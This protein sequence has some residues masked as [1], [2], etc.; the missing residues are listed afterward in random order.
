MGR[1]IRA[2]V[3]P[4]AWM[5]RLLAKVQLADEVKRV[6]REREKVERKLRKLGQVYLND[7]LMDYEEYRRQKRQLEDQLA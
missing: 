7:D 1:I 2:L 6:E 5:H 3:L 4:D